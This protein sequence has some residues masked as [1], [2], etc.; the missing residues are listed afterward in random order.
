MIFRPID[1]APTC[2]GVATKAISDKHSRAQGRDG[3]FD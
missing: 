3:R 1:I 2:G